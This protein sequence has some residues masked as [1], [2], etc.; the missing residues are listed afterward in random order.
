LRQ[1]CQTPNKAT[2]PHKFTK[3]AKAI[4]IDLGTS[5]SRVAVYQNGKVEVIANEAG[6]RTTPSYV[7][8][9]D[10]E[11]LIGDAAKHQVATNP[12]N[13]VFDIKRLIGRK[14][15]DNAVQKDMENWPFKV[16]NDDGKPKIKVECQGTE[17]SFFPEEISSMVLSKMKQIAENYL[18]AAVSNAVVTVPA[19]FNDSQRQATKDAGVIAGLNVLRVINEPTSAAIAYG[20]DTCDDGEKH[21]LVFDLGGGTFDV[22]AISISDGVFEVKATAGDTN[23]GGKDFDSCMVNYFIQEFKKQHKKDIASNKLAVFR[24]R[25][26]CE[27]AKQTLSSSTQASIEIDS[28]F[29][30]IDFHTIITRTKFDQLNSSLLR[31]ML[32]PVEKVL[33]DARLSKM[34]IDEVVMVGGSTRIPKIKKRLIDFFNG[35]PF[36]DSV[37]PDELVACGAAIQAAILT[38][39][40]TVKDIFLIDVTSQAL[41]V[42]TKGGALTPLIKRNTSIP[43]EKLMT[44]T[45]NSTIQ[46]FEGER[47]TTK[48]NNMLG[49][50]ELSGISPGGV[51]NTEVTFHIDDNGILS[52]TAKDKSAGQDIT[53]R[54]DKG[55]LSLADVERMAAEAEKYKL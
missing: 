22:S 2:A 37:N 9:N 29:E 14:F 19:Y 46:V 7:G 17:K 49:K 33:G 48:L 38:G 55:R 41:G 18:G 10:Q 27:Q 12:A 1:I 5:Y 30:G 21:V 45:S 32:E 3:M 44:Y 28:L 53:V 26:A 35:K 11:I 16:E 54:I 25:T 42:E 4:G 43:I 36:C 40:D 50:F 8:F 24:L 31:T 52:V 47:K 6:N 23:F 39:D 13:T 34:Q 51:S 20:L 15:D